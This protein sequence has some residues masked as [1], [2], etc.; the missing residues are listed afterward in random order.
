M[1][2][3]MFRQTGQADATKTN[4]TGGQ[5][6]RTEPQ[7]LNLVGTSSASSPAWYV[8]PRPLA[9]PATLIMILQ[10]MWDEMMKRLAM[11]ETKEGVKPRDKAK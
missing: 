1:L 9:M 3:E 5:D 11:L 2:A 4:N 6:V 8:P 10:T 7:T